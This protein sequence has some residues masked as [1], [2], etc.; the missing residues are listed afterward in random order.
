[1]LV[2]PWLGDGAIVSGLAQEIEFTINASAINDF[3]AGAL[4]SI[5]ANLMQISFCIFSWFVTKKAHPPRPKVIN[6]NRG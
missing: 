3:V 2:V 4:F 5:E 1:M 6:T